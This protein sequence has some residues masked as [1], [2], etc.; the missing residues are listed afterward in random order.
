MKW[1]IE[2]KTAVSLAVAGLILLLVAG[3][4]YRNA[5]VFIEA[6]QWVSHTH[7]VLAELEVTLST[8][9][10]AQAATRGY[11]ITGQEAF[12]E[13]YQAAAPA[14]Q[15]HLDRLKSLT[16][17]NPDQQR[18][19]A[20]L[21][22]AVAQQLDSLRVSI[23]LR[24][25]RGFK[26]ARERVTTGI[27]TKQMNEIRAIISEMKQE[28]QDLLRRRA[29]DFEVSTRKTALTF[30]SVIFLEFLLLAGVYYVLRRDVSQLENAN[31]FINLSLDMFC[32]AG[33]DGFFKHLNPAWEQVLGFTAQELMA[34]PYLEFI[35]PEDRQAT[36]AEAAHIKDGEITF[37]FENRYLCKDGSYK[38]LLWNA[39]SVPQQ[40]N[41][42]AVSRDITER[43]HFEEKLRE[44]EDR[45]RKLFDNNPHPT[46]VFDR[47]TQRFLAVNAAAVRKY[48][49]SG[50]EFLAMTIKHIHPPED[51]PVLLKSVGS[52]RDGNENA[53]TRRHRR[54]DGTIIDVE[55][56]SYALTFAGRPAEVVVAADVTVRKRAE[57]EKREFTKTLAASNREL[58]VRNRQVEHATKLKSKFLASMSHEL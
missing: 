39:I 53:G 19:L 9:A 48:G 25:N 2:K 10:D 33:F 21:E 46:W 11:I 13:P 7:D 20:L 14:T 38:W 36:V 15:A 23:D 12:L 58:E 26:A 3:M 22:T 17:D 29:R 30:S 50:D 49:Y 16:S 32:T 27:G 4:S 44:S 41:L 28:E 31:R 57:E 43:K 34:K 8:V 24:R 54:K 40:E 45:H 18:H 5:R 42:F 47:E 55:I 51:V 35:H 52:I 6:N 1:S 37:A 56:T